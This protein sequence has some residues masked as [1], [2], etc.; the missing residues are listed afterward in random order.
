MIALLID[1]VAHFFQR[2]QGF[3][4]FRIRVAGEAFG[5]HGGCRAAFLIGLIKARQ[6]INGNRAGG[7]KILQFGLRKR[8]VAK[9]RIGKNFVQLGLR[10]RLF[11][12]RQPT[13]VNVENIDKAQ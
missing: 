13:R 1:K 2:K 10:A 5:Q 7:R 4:V 12:T 11:V 3:G 6:R 9:H 8:R